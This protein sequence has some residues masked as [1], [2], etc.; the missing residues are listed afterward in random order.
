MIQDSAPVLVTGGTGFV[1]SHLVEHLAR[2][3]VPV[4]CVTRATS[5]TQWLPPSVQRIPAL[6][7]DATAMREALQG[8]GHVYHLAAATSSVDDA[9]YQR[10]NISLTEALLSAVRDSAPSARVVLCSTLAA[11]GPALDGRP[12]TEDDPPRPIGPYG[13][14]KLAAERL[15]AGSGLDH[16]I[17]RP[18]AVYG[19]RDR[20]ILEVFR[21]ARFG[22]VPSFAPPGQLLSLVHVRDLAEGMHLAAVRGRPG[23][24]Y[25]VA[26]GPPHSWGA[27][28]DAM[29]AAV[30]RRVRFVR[31]PLAVGAVAARASCTVARLTAAKPLLTS[32]RVRNMAQAAWICDDGKARRELGYAP[33]IGLHEGMTETAR[34]YRSQGWM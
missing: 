3:R 14:T 19:P 2:A 22:L 16:V 6:L 15:V 12:L 31:L 18:P 9:G 4:R 1:G 10:S 11:G 20:D 23:Q 32:E 34:W 21:F 29:G 28:V 26:D 30:Q 24:L 7:T 5:N 27:I 25:Y 17:V 8:V 33:S 13:T